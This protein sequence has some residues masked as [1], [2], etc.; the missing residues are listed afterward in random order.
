M[1]LI[2][3]QEKGRTYE[4]NYKKDVSIKDNFVKDYIGVSDILFGM[5]FEYIKNTE[6]LKLLDLGLAEGGA[7][8]K[9]F[10]SLGAS[11]CGVDNSTENVEKCQKK[12]FASEI[13]QIDFTNLPLPFK[14]AVFDLVV[15]C[16]M[17]NDQKEISDLLRDIRR[18]LKSEGFF[19]FSVITGFFVPFVHEELT[20]KDFPRLWQKIKDNPEFI[21]KSKHRGSN[22]GKK[23]FEG[24]KADEIQNEKEK[25]IF[26]IHSKE[27]LKEILN[28]ERFQIIKKVE[29]I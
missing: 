18:M 13:Q 28:E 29:V 17:L 15:S 24:K 2:I 23:G 7:S 6:N 8:S 27:N 4:I 14:D 19:A 9:L 5:L 11:I 10:K 3:F 22:V 25:K 20:E 1:G 16:G 12:H 26:Y 21:F